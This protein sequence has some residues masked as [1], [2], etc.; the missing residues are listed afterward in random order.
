M[1]QSQQS[2]H[3]SEGACGLLREGRIFSI[4]SS[5]NSL[6]G[7]DSKL[8]F[9]KYTG[10]ALWEVQN[11]CGHPGEIAQISQ[12]VPCPCFIMH[13][14]LE[15]LLQRPGGQPFP[16]DRFP[17]MG[18][19]EPFSL[20]N[21]PRGLQNR[22]QRNRELLLLEAEAEDGL[23]MLIWSYNSSPSLVFC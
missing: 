5:P 17:F 16:G 10:H 1:R 2:C 22:G 20:M 8:G 21:H 23:S 14:A 7:Q 9:P 4:C 12:T 3:H 15:S 18:R 11:T 19:L 6:V 13:L